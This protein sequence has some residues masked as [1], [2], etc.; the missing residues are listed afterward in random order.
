MDATQRTNREADDDRIGD[1]R[2]RVAVALQ[3]V[4]CRHGHGGSADAG[5]ELG[6]L[7]AA[8][9]GAGRRLGDH[10]G[11]QAAF[12]MSPRTSTSACRP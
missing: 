4:W 8:G 6:W 11:H 2:G 3:R 5:V 10:L 7:W 9:L 12:Q 1:R